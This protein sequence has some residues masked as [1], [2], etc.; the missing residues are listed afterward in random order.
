LTATHPFRPVS[1]LVVS[2][3]LRRIIYPVNSSELLRKIGFSRG[4]V[5]LYFHAIQ[6]FFNKKLPSL[7][8]YLSIYQSNNFK[9]NLS[10]K[11]I[12]FA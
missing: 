7:A 12:F 10:E 4:K 8:I 6:I 2:K 3:Q 11:I 9:K 1:L 5:N